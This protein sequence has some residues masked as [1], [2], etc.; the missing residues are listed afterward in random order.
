VRKI[1]LGRHQA[2]CAIC[3]HPDREQIE[4]EWVNWGPTSYTARRYGVSRDGIY[5][6]AHALGLFRKRERNAIRVLEK[7]IERVDS[8]EMNCA[9]MLSALKLCLSL[10]K[11]PDET[12]QVQD[13]PPRELLDKTSED[14]RKAIATDG[15]LPP[16]DTA[17]KGAT[18]PH[19]QDGPLGGQ[20]G[21]NTTLQ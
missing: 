14:E 7:M 15:S 8:T 4:E 16:G 3:N 6:H 11:Q 13:M 20:A 9:T 18:P 21:E 2:Q 1:N 17:E 12:P 10:T 19:S 5:R